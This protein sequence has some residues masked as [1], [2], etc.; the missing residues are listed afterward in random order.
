MKPFI[1]TIFFASRFCVLVNGAE[2]KI[3]YARNGKIFGC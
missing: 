3:A 2:R 1:V